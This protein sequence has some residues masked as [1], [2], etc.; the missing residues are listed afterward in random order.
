MGYKALN[1]VGYT[2]QSLSMVGSHFRL[3]F[4]YLFIYLHEKNCKNVE[5]SFLERN[6]KLT[7]FLE[8]K[9]RTL[10]HSPQDSKS[11]KLI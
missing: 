6:G 2:E 11:S 5:F 7:I 8:D 9:I 3:Q 1:E 4:M 10:N